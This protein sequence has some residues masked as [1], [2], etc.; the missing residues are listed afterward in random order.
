MSVY[1]SY[2]LK[3]DGKLINYCF[4]DVRNGEFYCVEA[5]GDSLDE[6][7]SYAAYCEG[8]TEYTML[9]TP[10]SDMATIGCI[11]TLSYEAKLLFN[12]NATGY[13]NLYFN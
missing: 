6:L 3:K 4:G 10:S 13:L 5:L 2:G 11:K 12:D 9:S 8:T 7:C 1:K